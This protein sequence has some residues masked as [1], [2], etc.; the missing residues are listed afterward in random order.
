M[1]PTLKYIK[2]T[3]RGFEQYFDKEFKHRDYLGEYQNFR[4]IAYELHNIRGAIGDEY[5]VKHYKAMRLPNGRRLKK[6]IVLSKFPDMSNIIAS[7]DQRSC[8][9]NFKDAQAF[10]ACVVADE[11]LK[12][13]WA[14]EYHIKTWKV[15][16]KA[17]SIYMQFLKKG[18]KIAAYLLPEMPQQE[19]VVET[20]FI[21]QPVEV[22]ERMFVN[23]EGLLVECHSEE[24]SSHTFGHLLREEALVE[25]DVREAG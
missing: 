22:S 20:T 1:E 6:R 17:L 9:N 25:E 10:A 12:A 18:Q 14:K 5:V 4:Q 24:M 16:R 21:E 23:D 7:K 13:A 8:R 3:K 2:T 11:E 19:E 15:Y